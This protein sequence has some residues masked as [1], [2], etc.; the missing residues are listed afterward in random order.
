MKEINFGEYIKEKRIE[1][2]LSLRAL[3]EL[4][5]LSAGYLLDIEKGRRSA[6]SGDLLEKIIKELELD[7][8]KAYDLAG[9]SR[10]ELPEDIVR[11]IKE[12][13]ELIVY[14]R[15]KYFKEERI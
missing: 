8:R 4:I 15:E 13:P 6:L 10:G 2:K 12:N 11:I 9:E 3:G 14:I 5:G 7:A 1:K